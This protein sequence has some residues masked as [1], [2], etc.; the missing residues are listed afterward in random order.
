M[1]R[2]PGALTPRTIRALRP[3]H[4][5]PDPWRAFGHQRERER[6]ADGTLADALTVFLVGRTCPFTCVFC[7][8]WRFTIADPTPIGALPAQLAQV[9]DEAAPIPASSLVK[10]YNASNFFD[11]KAVP[12]QDHAALATLVRPFRRVVVECHAKLVGTACQRFAERLEGRLEVAM[13]L[14]TVHPEAFPRLRK[15]MTL[16]DF[17]RAARR[18]ADHAIP[19]RAFVQIGAPFVP[20]EEDAAWVTRAMVHAFERGAEH[21]ALI[22]AR[23][24][25]GAMERLAERGHWTPPTLDT[26]EQAF[27]HCLAHNPAGVVTVDPWDLAALR[28]CDACLA[29]RLERIERINLTGAWQPRV[30]C[31]RCGGAAT[32]APGDPRPEVRASTKKGAP[33]A[34]R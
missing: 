18:L 16:H 19:L 28:D 7:D 9:L 34:R 11:T 21:V 1:S 17:D 24:G 23:G 8:L 4:K 20:P 32:V 27:D 3:I 14:E 29:G 2:G 13:G 15:G 5:P 22:P 25:N 10:L 26:V 33:R 12:P 6:Q 31:A 30:A